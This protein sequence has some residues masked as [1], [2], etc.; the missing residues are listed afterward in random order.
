MIANLQGS[1]SFPGDQPNLTD[2]QSTETCTIPHPSDPIKMHI[3]VSSHMDPGWTYTFEELYQGVEH[4]GGSS[5]KSILNNVFDALSKDPKRKY[6]MAEVSYFERWWRDQS[7]DR[8]N[9]FRDFVKNKQWEFMNGGWTA[10]DEACAYYE[11]IMDNFIVGQRWLKDNFG[12]DTLIGWQID[13]FGNSA[14]HAALMAQ[15]GYEAHFFSRADEIDRELRRKEK[16]L[17]FNWKP[18]NPRGESVFTQMLYV[19]YADIR[20]LALSERTMFVHGRLPVEAY[21]KIADYMRKQSEAFKTKN[22]LFLVCDDFYLTKD[23]ERDYDGLEAIMEHFET[24]PEFGIK[25]K[26]TSLKGYLDEAKQDLVKEQH[27]LPEKLNDFFAYVDNKWTCWT[28]YYTSKSMFKLMI[29]EYS[30]YYNATK[31]FLSKLLLAGNKVVLDSADKKQHEQIN[32]ALVELEKSLGIAQHHDA[33]TGTMKDRVRYDYENILIEGREALNKTLNPIIKTYLEATLGE[34]VDETGVQYDWLFRDEKYAHVFSAGSTPL[35]AVYNPGH[36]RRFLIK[37]KVPG[38]SGAYNVVRDDNK[39]IDV[40]RVYHDFK[41]KDDCYIYFMDEI[42][43]FSLKN[44]KLVKTTEVMVL[45]SEPIGSKEQ[46]FVINDNLT[47]TVFEDLKTFK[48]EYKTSQ[49]KTLTDIFQLDYEYY[50]SSVEVKGGK[51]PSGAYIFAPRSQQKTRY[52][53]ILSGRVYKGKNFTLLQIFREDLRTDIKLIHS[54][55]EKGLEIETFLYPVKDFANGKEIVLSIRSQNINNQNGIFYTDGNGYFMQKRENFKREDYVPFEENGV[56][57]NYYPITSNA[58]IEDTETGQRLSIVT[59][60]GQGFTSIN[61]GELEVMIH[62]VTVRDDA[63]GVEEVLK[64]VDPKT[65]ELIKVTTKHHLLYSH[66]EVEVK[67]QR[68]QRQYDV[69][70]QVQMWF[71]HSKSQEFVHHH[72]VLDKKGVDNTVLPELVKLYVRSYNVDE[73]VVRLHN[74]DEENAKIVTLF[75]QATQ[76]SALLS[77][78]AGKEGIKVE[79][80]TELSWTTTRLKSELNLNEM[81]PNLVEVKAN[82]TEGYS[83][84]SLLPM[85]IRTFNI[86]IKS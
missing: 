29:R 58:Y 75:D 50:E 10:N 9:T 48:Y 1:N 53:T 39:V 61:P 31:L 49:G 77:G 2:Q 20:F 78:F 42:P 60:R 83:S 18:K 25:P 8:R 24:H 72:A 70:R 82:D 66:P 74:L 86:V 43:S 15:A 59:D 55:P 51:N 63:K 71:Y 6:S 76:V 27:K 23:A 14:T 65:G 19:L 5:V 64:E 7:E 12:L 34:P 47:L 57:T 46:A 54:Q 67:D 80:V 81:D 36:T 4:Q 16:R 32:Q 56:E 37:V 45:E 28:G 22:I 62:R 30:Q 40:D 17:Q 26:Y 68:R 35:I 52:S 33:V 41:C 85:E 69:D 73:Y 38:D 79:S 21:D 11:D 84:V 3:V 44:Y 13:S